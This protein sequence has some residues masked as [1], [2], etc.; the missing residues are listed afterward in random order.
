VTLVLDASMAL[1]WH[2]R[3]Q[4]SDESV[5]AQ[6]A[7]QEVARQGAIVP[8]LCYSEIGNG[9]LMGERRHLTDADQIAAFQMDLA[10]LSI[11]LDSA[12]PSTTLSK[13]L[14]LARSWGLTSYDA[15]Y[16]ELVLRTKWPLATF[17]RRLA[18]A[19]RKAGGRVFG[20]PT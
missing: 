17:D 6:S 1:A 2:L 3:R 19:V 20:D 4:D 13:V 15:T 8:G 16:L 14:S 11:S 12:S 9:L 5:L 7:L 10:Q 18:E